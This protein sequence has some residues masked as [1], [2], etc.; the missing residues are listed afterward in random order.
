MHTPEPWKLYESNG[1]AGIVDEDN[2][3]IISSYMCGGDD[4]RR[5]AACVNACA[6]M[7]GEELD[8]FSDGTLKEWINDAEERL[9]AVDAALDD[10]DYSGHYEKGIYSLKQQRDELAKQLKVFVG[11]GGLVPEYEFDY[12]RK[13]IA[14]AQEN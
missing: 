5:V 10:V 6:G 9:K 7:T 12:A 14:K 13:L 1:V 3:F 4:M 11:N 2:A 8:E